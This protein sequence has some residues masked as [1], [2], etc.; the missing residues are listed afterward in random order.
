MG[1]MGNTIAPAALKEML[2]DGKEL[3]LLD[4]REEGVFSQAH[5][6]LACSVPLSQLE[7]LIADMVPRRSARTVLCD[8]SD[9][10]AERAAE[11]LASFGY[12]DVAV[13]WRAGL[14]PGRPTSGGRFQ[15]EQRRRS[16]SFG[17][18]LSLPPLT[19]VTSFVHIIISTPINIHA[20]SPPAEE[21]E[22]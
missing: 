4:V 14:R 6:L 3:A 16:R 5:L 15:V 12:T 17:V 20:Y 19:R 1:L 10:L 2:V 11:K 18:A 8:A 13:F 9:G 7:L 21:P 22:D